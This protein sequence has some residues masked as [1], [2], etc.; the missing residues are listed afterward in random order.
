MEIVVCIKQVPSGEAY[1]DKE[2]GLL[3]RSATG[4]TINAN[5]L[6]A[7]EMAYRMKKETGAKV[8]AI[9]MGPSQA[10]EALRI[11]VS[12]G[13][14]RAILLSDRAFAGADVYATAYTLAQGINVI[15][16]PDLIL[17]GQQTTD[18]DTAQVPFSLSVKLDVPCMGW[19]K[20]VKEIKENFISVIQETTGGTVIASSSFPCLLAFTAD[21]AVPH[22]PSI[23]QRMAA[24]R[25]EIEI[26]A[27]DDLLIQEVN[28][29]GLKGSPTRVK[30]IF[31]P[32]MEAK[33]PPMVLTPK[34]AAEKIMEELECL[35]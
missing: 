21:C 33:F 15:D 35:F 13:A 29:F 31:S 2:T 22:I 17:C 1:M 6:V 4:N 32:T 8:T 34:V 18:G 7:L 27:L 28:H 10:T 5:D 3:I 9:T 19:V 12:M 14:D 30:R 25:A 16:P 23:T 26:I 20:S 11:A 24:K